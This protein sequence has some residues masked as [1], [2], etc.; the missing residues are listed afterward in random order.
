MAEPTIKL[1]FTGL[2]D[3]YWNKKDQFKIGAFKEESHCLT[4]G[5]QKLVSGKEADFKVFTY[6]DK[7]VGGCNIKHVSGK[8]VRLEVMTKIGEVTKMGERKATPRPSTPI[9]KP[10]STHDDLR[11]CINLD[12]PGFHSSPKKAL[13]HKEYYFSPIIHIDQGEFHTEVPISVIQE[14]NN[15]PV[16]LVHVAW[17]VGADINLSQGQSAVLKFGS[18]HSFTFTPAEKT[19]YVVFIE[20]G[21]YSKDDKPSD[22][23]DFEAYYKC[24]KIKSSDQYRLR[25]DEDRKTKDKAIRKKYPVI[26]ATRRC[27][28]GKEIAERGSRENPCDPTYTQH[29]YY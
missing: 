20:N 19:N 23:T 18:G 17:Y 21:C 28:W 2:L 25:N 12:G 3:F 7:P 15:K 8:E 13:P 4:I 29:K 24:F 14:K 27:V 16:R 6:K 9:G 1:L 11:H 26:D 22:Y 10:P 5:V